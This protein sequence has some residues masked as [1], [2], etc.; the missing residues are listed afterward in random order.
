MAQ[1]TERI[2]SPPRESSSR[3]SPWREGL[4]SERDLGEDFLLEGKHGD[5]LI[6]P[7]F[8]DRRRRAEPLISSTDW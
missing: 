5:C 8:Y 3:N 1:K 4:D 2:H 6:R 7:R